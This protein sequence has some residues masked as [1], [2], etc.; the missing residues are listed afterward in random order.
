MIK[1]IKPIHE[2]TAEVEIPTGQY[3]GSFTKDCIQ[4]NVPE[5]PP[6]EIYTSEETNKPKQVMV[7]I[8]GPLIYVYDQNDLK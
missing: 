2:C 7:L 4:F 6:C 3:E 5:H 8:L 1:T